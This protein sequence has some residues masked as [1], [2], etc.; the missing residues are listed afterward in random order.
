MKSTVQK[1]IKKRKLVY[2]FEDKVFILNHLNTNAR[3][4]TSIRLSITLRLFNLSSN[5]FQNRLVSRCI[6]TSRKSKLHKNFRFSRLFFLKAARL[7]LISG[8]KKS[9]W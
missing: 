9:K 5:S 4:K 6:F 2:S 7:G 8:L 1:D 3:L